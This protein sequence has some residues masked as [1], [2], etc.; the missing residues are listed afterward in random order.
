MIAA[1]LLV[2]AVTAHVDPTSAE[3]RPASD[4]TPE[5][6]PFNERGIALVEAGQHA[7]GVAELERAYALLPDPLMHRKGRSKVLGSIRSTLNRLHA[8]TGDPAY[9]ERLQAH[10][11]RYIEGLLLALGDAATA[12]DVEF[13]LAA[14]RDVSAMLSALQL[15]STDASSPTMAGPPAPAP[16]RSVVA[17]ARPDPVAVTRGG[18]RLRVTGGVLIGVGVAA[19]GVMTGAAVASAD[20]RGK[21]RGLTGSLAE[22]GLPASPTV[23]LQGE[24]YYHR[25]GA[26]QAVAITTGVIGGVALAA[27]IALRIVGKRRT[28]TSARR[29][30]TPLLAPGV[31]GVLLGGA[32]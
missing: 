30:L 10:L 24:R 31:V 19:L 20:S 21:L 14:L 25:A 27:G 22:P 5:A 23:W 6:R 17:P 2:V 18:Q 26:Y 12:A 13:S 15:P 11:L 28:P 8:A 7:A 9:L 3:R 29:S 4:L 32:F 16:A 1:C